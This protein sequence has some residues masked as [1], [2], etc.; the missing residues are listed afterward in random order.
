MITP[1]LTWF[2]LLGIIIAVFAV[3]I[4]R[5]VAVKHKKHSP[6]ITLGTEEEEFFAPGDPTPLHANEDY[7]E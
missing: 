7:N 6:F 1:I 5:Q 3:T 2:C 4:I